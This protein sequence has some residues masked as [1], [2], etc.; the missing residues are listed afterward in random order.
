MC[1]FRGVK[2]AFE[3]LS[4]ASHLQACMCIGA[5]QHKEASEADLTCRCCKRMCTVCLKAPGVHTRSPSML[6]RAMSGPRERR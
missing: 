5:W 4:C 3:M 1:S 6:S 2:Q